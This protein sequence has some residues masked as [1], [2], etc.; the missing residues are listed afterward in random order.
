[1]AIKNYSTT[2]ANNNATP[3]N[4][5]P[6]GSTYVNQLTD[7]IRQGRADVR[8]LYETPCWRDLGHTPTYVGSTSFTVVGNQTAFY[9]VNQRLRISDSSTLYGTISAVAY[10]T[11]TLVTVTLDSGSI[12]S[13]ITAV[14]VGAG[15]SNKALHY[16][17]IKGT[18]SLVTYVHPAGT[19]EM[20]AGS[21]APSGW[22]LCYGQAVSRT[23]YSALFTAISTAFGVGDGST[24]FN[25]PDLRGRAVFGVDNMG[26]SAA[27]RITVGV[28]GV[29]GTTL[30]AVGGSEAMQTHTHGVTDPA[31]T[32]ALGNYNNTYAGGG[33]PVNVTAQTGYS[34]TGTSQAT[35]SSVTGVTINN[36]GS[37]SSQNVPPA[38]ML[39][40]VISTG[41]V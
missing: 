19:V 14:A 3:P 34:A 8:E 22:L 5:A 28:S 12:T 38:I 1:M 21:T 23:T 10:T 17:M 26:G 27:N 2:A 36:A 13:G 6:E 41:G 7:I 15:D 9:F 24:T 39:N 40:Y 11:N 20:F 33:G 29:A 37:G 25:L 32:H 18:P 30:G 31:H 4:G 16:E 35:G